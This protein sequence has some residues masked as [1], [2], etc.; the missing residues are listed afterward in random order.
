MVVAAGSHRDEAFVACRYVI[1]ET[2]RRVPIWK[3]ERYTDGSAAW[4]D[5]TAPGGVRPIATAV[6]V[7]DPQS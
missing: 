7:A 3:R 4:V 5:P 6:P 2:K 1:E